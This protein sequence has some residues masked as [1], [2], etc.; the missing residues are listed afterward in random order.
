MDTYFCYLFD[1]IN[2]SRLLRMSVI[3]FLEIERIMSNI[4]EK[5]RNQSTKPEK[6][7]LKSSFAEE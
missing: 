2:T 7:E 4:C 3:G 5:Q 6:N 1:A